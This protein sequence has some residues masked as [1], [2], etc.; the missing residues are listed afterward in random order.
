MVPLPGRLYVHT[1]SMLN[2]RTGGWNFDF[3]AASIRER[4]NGWN[5]DGRGALHGR[6][7]ETLGPPFLRQR[8]RRRRNAG[9]H[10]VL[11]RQI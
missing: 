1:A 11:L 3:K 8:G 9:A 10:A 5:V 6:S 4:C 7:L 2:R